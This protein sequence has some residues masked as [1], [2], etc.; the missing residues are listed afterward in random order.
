[1]I[2]EDGN[3]SALCHAVSRLA[4]DAEARASLAERGRRRAL[5]FD[6]ENR[7]RRSR[8]GVPVGC[9]RG[10]LEMPVTVSIITPCYNGAPF[11]HATL[12]SALAQTHAPLEV[13]VVDDGSTDESAAI[14]EAF[15]TPVRVIRQANQGESVA[16]NRALAE[17]RG[18]T[19]AL[20]RRRR[21]AGADAPWSAW[22]RRSKAG[23]TR[24]RSWA[25]PGF[26]RIRRSLFGQAAGDR[27]VLPGDHRVESRAA[28]LL[29]GACGAGATR[30][31][32]LRGPALVRG[33]GSLVAG[34]AATPALVTVPM[35]ARCTGGIPDRN[36]RRRSW[37]TRRAGT[38]C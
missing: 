2:V 25:A 9:R 38:P 21:P 37:P 27:D 36:W 5:A 11:L 15:G 13:I 20:S 7:D 8:S 14:A 29:A 18:I 26:P 24:W 17:A 33:L 6:L 32:V 35:S 1:M 12:Q 22:C 34:G 31:R 19:R 4:C 3:V 10:S 23:R 30:G 28:A 16:R